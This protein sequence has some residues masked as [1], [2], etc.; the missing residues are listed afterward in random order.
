MQIVD[1]WMATLPGLLCATGYRVGVPK[2]V[3]LLPEMLHLV[4]GQEFPV[5]L[6]AEPDGLLRFGAG[7]TARAFIT[8]I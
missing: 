2:V 6:C 4:L 8:H 7:H 3:P 1:R 5:V